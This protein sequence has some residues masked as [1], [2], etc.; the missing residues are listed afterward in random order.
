MISVT[1]YE[2]DYDIGRDHRLQLID[3][4]GEGYLMQTPPLLGEITSKSI[5]YSLNGSKD[6]R[7]ML[8]TSDAMY[9]LE[10]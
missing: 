3:L 10:Q 7:L 6:W 9:I 4:D 5:Q 2:N 8:G 1:L